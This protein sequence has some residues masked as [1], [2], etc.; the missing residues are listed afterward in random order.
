MKT[1]RNDWLGLPKG[2][3]KGVK[4]IYAEFELAVTE[5]EGVLLAKYDSKVTTVTGTSRNSITAA[6]KVTRHNRG[7]KAR[8][9]SKFNEKKALAIMETGRKPGVGVSYNRLKRWAELKGIPPEKIP[10]IAR[11][12]KAAGTKQ[13]RRGGHKV[14]S[15]TF[16]QVERYYMPKLLTKTNA[17]L[18]KI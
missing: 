7:I 5:M 2:L 8:I 10:Q 4:K 14:L 3:D 17:I 15:S 16:G 18:A 13:W 1:I 6:T 9:G 12:I 11:K